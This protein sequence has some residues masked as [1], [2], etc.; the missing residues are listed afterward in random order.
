[1]SFLKSLF[2]RRPGDDE[3]EPAPEELGEPPG[4]HRNAERG[5]AFRVCKVTY[6]TGYTRR[7]VVVDISETGVRV[8][9]SDRGELPDMV[10][11]DIERVGRR[12]ARLVWS[13]ESDAGFQFEASP[14]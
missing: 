4:D 6:T 11:L 2:G 7:G 12:S 5:G 3:P 8:R 9:F 10:T 1:M 14:D 13:D